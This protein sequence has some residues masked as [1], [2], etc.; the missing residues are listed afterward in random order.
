MCN[1]DAIPICAA[2]PLRK[3]ARFRPKVSFFVGRIKTQGVGTG[4]TQPDANP[5]SRGTVSL[6]SRASAI[7]LTRRPS[8]GPSVRWASR[9]R[10][11]DAASAYGR[12]VPA[13]S[14]E[15]ARRRLL[16]RPN[17]YLAPQGQALTHTPQMGFSMWGRPANPKQASAHR[18][19]S[20]AS[21]RLR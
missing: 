5:S 14:A 12:Q 10:E 20:R 16:Q 2:R 4:L 7:F 18:E 17:S 8:F 1:P 19:N 11:P 9:R 6:L 13:L 21:S 15:K 3:K